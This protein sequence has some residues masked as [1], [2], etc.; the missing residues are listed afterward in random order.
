MVEQAGHLAVRLC[1]RGYVSRASK[2]SNSVQIGPSGD[3][4]SSRNGNLGRRI[5]DGDR[6]CCTKSR[7]CDLSKRCHK[8]KSNV[9][10]YML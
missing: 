8:R 2:Q 6:E 10:H 7:I 9:N 1:M 4:K 5:S 3:A